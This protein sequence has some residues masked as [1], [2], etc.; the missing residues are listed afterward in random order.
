MSNKVLVGVGIGACALACAA[1]VSMPALVGVGVL[2]AGGALALISG[3]TL[4][5]VICLAAVAGIGAAVFFWNRQRSQTKMQRC[6]GDGSCGCKA[7]EFDGMK[8]P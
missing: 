8:E 5:V 1:A 6:L 3:A 4:E 7:T 2:G